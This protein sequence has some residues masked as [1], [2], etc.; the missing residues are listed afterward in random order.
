MRVHYLYLYYVLPACQTN[1][2][3][4]FVTIFSVVTLYIDVISLP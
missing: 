3:V 4:Q 1:I 2:Y